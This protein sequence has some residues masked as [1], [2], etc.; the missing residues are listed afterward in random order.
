MSVRVLAV[1]VLSLLLVAPSTSGADG[2]QDHCIVRNIETDGSTIRVT[3][4]VDRNE[5]EQHLRTQALR[6][7][8][9]ASSVTISDVKL[10][11]IQW[12]RIDP[13][14]LDVIVDV[15]ATIRLFGHRLDIS[16][17]VAA[18]VKLGI[19]DA[20]AVHADLILDKLVVPGRTIRLNDIVNVVLPGLTVQLPRT[21][22]AGFTSQFQLREAT[23]RLQH[24]SIASVDPAWFEVVVEISP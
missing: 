19:V 17:T 22:V 5:V 6:V 9:Q 8:V 16:G 11:K 1:A 4:D 3:V 18:Q 15:G 23:G 14:S 10:G 24:M 21:V 7:V 12:V 20:K 13:T 2:L